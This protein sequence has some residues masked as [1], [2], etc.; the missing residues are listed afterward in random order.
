MLRALA[1]F[2]AAVV[3]ASGAVALVPSAT[4]A[5]TWNDPR[6]R[7]LVERATERRAAQLADTALAD[8]QATAHGYLTFLAQVGE[9][10][11]EPP[12]IVKADELALEVYWRSPDLS[13]QRIIGRRDTLLLPTD[14]NYHRDH[15]GI[16]QNNFPNIIR[17]GE[18]DE[19]RDVPHPLSR[20]GLAQY[21]Y[22]I[23][24][25]LKIRLPDRTIDVLEVRVKPKNDRAPAAVGAVYIDRDQATV[26]RMAFSFTRAALI[27]RQ[28]EDVSIVLENSLI[29]NRFWLPRR[30]EIEIRRTGSWLDYPARGII[31]GRWEI[32]CYQVNRGFSRGQF[33]GPEIV[34][35]P[36]SEQRRY[37]WQGKILDSLPPDVRVA[38]DEDVRRVQ[39]DARSLVRATALART[40]ETSLSAHSVSDFARVNRV[41]GLALGLGIGRRFGDGFSSRLAGRYGFSDHEAK[42]ELLVGWQRA[43][44]SGLQFRVFRSF[45]DT[46][47]EPET[48]LLRNT[49][50]A[51]E[52]GSDYTDPYD[53]R[54]A[55]LTVDFGGRFGGRWRLTG[56]YEWQDSLRVNATP[57]SGQYEPTLAAWKLHEP[58]V[59]VSFERPTALT[60]GGV[61]A[62]LTGHVRVAHASVEEAPN[63]VQGT[64][65]GRAWLGLQAERPFGGFRLA[66]RTSVGSTIGPDLPR[67]EFVFLGGPTSAPGYEFH[68]LV[69][70][71]G[72]SE[73]VE[74]RF[75]IPF[76]ALPLGRYGNTGS[77]ATLAPFA[78]VAYLAQVDSAARSGGVSRGAG[79][80]PSVGVGLLTLFD[81]LRVDVAKGLRDGRWAFSVD[82]IRDFWSIL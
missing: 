15:L 56:G 25:S 8:Y 10:F 14:I 57:A 39:E 51:Q 70:G 21:D 46:G 3:V 2:T 11:P 62:R 65:F 33:A 36:L 71:F 50:A 43:D 30:Q 24:D 69:G 47:D 81:L 31:R 6:T 28:L 35:A 38:T 26:V 40:R 7:A 63:G 23:S 64:T 53:A 80:Y 4:A 29:D 54:G 76:V 58:R 75:S 59:E 66:T 55:S 49:I 67:Q 68:E 34:Q 77:R 82:V 61:E 72:A 27:D 73:R 44:A 20:Q 37:A 19:V 1:A 18:G 78:H 22:V 13:K 45:R 42:G 5:Q 17:L 9:G 79:W 41:E 48:S 60:V 16:V 32:C 12:K 52:F 74:G